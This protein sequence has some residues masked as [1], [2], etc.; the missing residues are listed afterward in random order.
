MGSFPL[1][2]FGSPMY[3]SDELENTFKEL[4]Q[5]HPLK[6]VFV[7]DEIDMALLHADPFFLLGSILSTVAQ[8]WTPILNLMNE[9]ISEFHSAKVTEINPLLETLRQYVG[10][11]NRVEEI[12]SEGLRWIEQGG[13]ESWPSASE[14][15]LRERKQSFQKLLQADFETLQKR[16]LAITR[17]CE[18]ATNLLVSYSQLVSSER[19]VD[20][21]A[22]VHSL[23]KLASVFVPVSFAATLFGMNVKELKDNP[24]VWNYAV[25]AG[26]LA[27]VTLLALNWDL[28]KRKAIGPLDSI[29]KRIRR[30]RAFW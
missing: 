26:C 3:N 4:D 12:L 5:H 7:R 17:D 10:I 19:G 14:E 2:P 29:A 15:P 21:A 11:L 25:L 9:C 1:I 30:R 18:S 22:Q 16:C 6:N 27:V 20:Q 28:T 8:S 13:C 24:S 23:T